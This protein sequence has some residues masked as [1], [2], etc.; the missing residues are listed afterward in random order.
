M[1]RVHGRFVAPAVLAVSLS[2]AGFATGPASAAAILTAADTVDAG[3]S[4]EITL[5]ADARG[6]IELWGPVQGIAGSAPKTR[7]LRVPVTGS[8]MDL[9]PNVAP[10]SYQLRLVSL[11]GDVLAK[12]ALDISTSPVALRLLERAE[13]GETAELT[14]FGPAAPGDRLLVVAEG[15]GTPVHEVPALG[16]AAREN[17]TEI[18]MPSQPGAYEIQYVTGAGIVL[19]ALPVEVS[20]ERAWLRSPLGV[21]AGQIFEVTWNGLARPGYAFVITAAEGGEAVGEP[22]SGT[23]DGRTVS[24]TLTAPSA[25]GAYQLA[26]LDPVTGKVV[27]DLPLDVDR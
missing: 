24:A 9:D 13:P 14:W 22:V 11:D 7:Q 23:V 18:P 19:H 16:N 20:E 12:Q 4:V 21:A 15:S 10:G 27:A 17:V 2:L 26:Y 5:P 1:T 3:H 8:R 25:P 6:W